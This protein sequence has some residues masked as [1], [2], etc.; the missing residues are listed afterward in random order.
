MSRIPSNTFQSYEA[1]AVEA[2]DDLMLQDCGL[3]RLGRAVV[4][5]A[6]D[7]RIVRVIKPSLLDRLFKAAHTT[8][9]L[10]TART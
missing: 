1:V 2:F 5:A 4:I 8:M 7:P 3:I 6:N 9:P 10:L